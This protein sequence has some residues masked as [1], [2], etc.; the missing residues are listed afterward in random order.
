MA[1][2]GGVPRRPLPSLASHQQ[3]ILQLRQL[4]REQVQAVLAFIKYLGEAKTKEAGAKSPRQT[5]RPSLQS[6]SSLQY[7][8][9]FRNI[10]IPIIEMPNSPFLH[11]P[12][13]HYNLLSKNR[14]LTNQYNPRLSLMES[15]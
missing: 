11:I 14:L 10:N 4:S 1:K 13:C 12:L 8:L 7:R 15:G 9:I 2:Y 6:V 3:T 5:C